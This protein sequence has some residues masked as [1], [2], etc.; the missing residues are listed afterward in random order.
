MAT[1]DFDTRVGEP[2]KSLRRANGMS[3]KSVADELGVSYQQ[4]QK[5]ENGQNKVSLEKLSVLAG[6]YDVKVEEILPINS[7]LF[8]SVAT[9]NVLFGLTSSFRETTKYRASA[10][11][12]NSTGNPELPQMP[13]MP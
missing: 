5:Y 9:A 4:I 3:T 6:L 8:S 13:Q 2:L 11:S 10:V 7:P 12:H 1:T